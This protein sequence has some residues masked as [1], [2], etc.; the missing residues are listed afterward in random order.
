MQATRNAPNPRLTGLGSG[1]FCIAS[2]LLLACLDLLLLDGSMPVYGVLFVL[3]STVTALWV[4]RADLAVP[5]IALP[6]AFAVGVLPIADGTGGFGGTVV[7]LFTALATQAG[8]LYGGTLTAGLI[9]AVRKF[10]QLIGQFAARRRATAATR[11]AVVVSQGTATARGTT[12]S[13]PAPGNG[14][15]PRRGPRP[16]RPRR[17]PA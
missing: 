3:V 1:L 2:M 10:C 9:V 15:A 6:I 16:P 12:K 5:P 13:P 7:G 4:R 17:R 11:N 8:W 14:P